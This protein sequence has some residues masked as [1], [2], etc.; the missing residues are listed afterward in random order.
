LYRPNILILVRA[1]DLLKILKVFLLF[2]CEMQ[3]LM[4]EHILMLIKILMMNFYNNNQSSHKISRFSNALS[5]T[6][7]TQRPRRWQLLAAEFLR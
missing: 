1:T 2:R 4:K 5:F 3:I 7:S 6:H